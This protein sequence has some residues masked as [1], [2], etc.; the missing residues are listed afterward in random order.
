MPSVIRESMSLSRRS[1]WAV[2]R[3]GCALLAGHVEPNEIDVGRLFFE[4][5]VVVQRILILDQVGMI[6]GDLNWEKLLEMDLELEL[7]LEEQLPRNRIWSREWVGLVR[8]EFGLCG[9][10]WFG[11]IVEAVRA[12]SREMGAVDE[13]LMEWSAEICEGAF[14]LVAEDGSDRKVGGVFYTP[15]ALVGYVLDQALTPELEWCGDDVDRLLGLRVCDP[16]CGCGYFLIET[17]RRISDRIEAAGGGNRIADVIQDCVFGGDINPLTA[18][19]CR[20]SLWFLAGDRAVTVDALRGNVVC[21]D[22]L[23]EEGMFG[24]RGRE[25]GFD[26][27][28]GNPPFLNQLG[29]GTAR[30][31]E[32]VKILRERGLVGTAAYTDE[33]SAFFVLGLGLVGGGGGMEEK[34]R[35]PPS[36]KT[37]TPPPEARGRSKIG[38]GRGDGLNR[39]VEEEGGGSADEEWK[40]SERVW[41][42]GRVCMVQPQSVVATR[43][44]EWMRSKAAEFGRLESIWVSN[45]HVFGDASVYTCVACVVVGEKEDLPQRSQREEGDEGGKVRRFSGGDFVEHEAIAISGEAFGELPTWSSIVAVTMGVPEVGI[46]SDGVVGDVA[47]ATA[48]FR[49]EY[50]GLVGK[51]V[52]DAVCEDREGSPGVLTTGLID[53]GVNHWGSKATRIHKRKWEGPRVC[54]SGIVGD[55]RLS[56]WVDARRVEK[57]VVA[58]QTK[59]VEA[60]VDFSGDFVVLTPMISVVV[61]DE[62]TACRRRS[63]R[64]TRLKTVSRGTLG[65]KRPDC[66]EDGESGHPVNMDV[67]MVGAAIGSPVCSAFAMR[68]FGGAAMHADALKMSARQVLELPLPGDLG[69]WEEG[70][71]LFEGVHLACQDQEKT[72]SVAARHLPRKPG[73]GGEECYADTSGSPGEEKEGKYAD[74]LVAFGEVMCGAYGVVGEE[75]DGLMGWWLGRLGIG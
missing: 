35:P 34:R 42:S 52:E 53:L 59:V 51:L 11:E 21:G 23:V 32:R 61:K 71:G 64:G 19:I 45:E 67:W 27:V 18:E 62:D 24:E 3:L 50:Y 15:A 37:Q 47:A 30:S 58:T 40:K 2:E 38:I 69:L 55:E 49:D 22:S 41:K 65:Q 25:K 28:V 29:A 31:V 17:T 57:V 70:A 5:R 68:F 74:A 6:D 8:R 72:P 66:A 1:K 73:G 48:D 36:A 43:G 60:F 20:W 39:P 9:G 33:A 54:A 44:G 75:R 12:D 63:S 46:V 13:S 14:G 10:K 16:A 7:F 4:L 56:K 26:V